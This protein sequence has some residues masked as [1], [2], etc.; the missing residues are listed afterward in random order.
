MGCGTET[1]KKEKLRENSS[2]REG[3]ITKNRKS[4]NYLDSK[5]N[6]KWILKDK[7]LIIILRVTRVNPIVA[8]ELAE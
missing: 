5:S 8:K 6:H 1:K 3:G 4:Q 7:K 2:K